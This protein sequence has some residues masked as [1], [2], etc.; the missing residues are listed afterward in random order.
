M[1]AGYRRK[2]LVVLVMTVV[3]VVTGPFGTFFDL[4]ILE[5]AYY[6]PVALVFITVPMIALT[7]LTLYRLPGNL[8]PILRIA[9]GAFIAGPIGAT[10]LLVLDTMVRH[11]EFT[12]YNLGFRWVFVT[13]IGFGV[14]VFEGYLRPMY[15]AA[16]E[17]KPDADKTAPKPAE[18]EPP[19]FVC[20]LEPEL[21]TELI[22]ITTQDH[23]LDVVTSNGAGRIL[24]RMS[25]ALAEL[26]G[27]PGMQIHRSHWVALHAVERVEKDGRK[28]Q[29]VLKNGTT[30]PVSRPNVP[31]LTEALEKR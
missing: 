23:Y 24:K 8:H 11:A 29:V 25:D 6:W 27:Y 4:T 26:N 21:G 18:P 7:E 13:L 28:C 12:P 16:P 1:R 14:G 20:N 17:P 2:I 22:S 9:V 5:R 19:L 31:V 3:A 10:A 15:H 30:L